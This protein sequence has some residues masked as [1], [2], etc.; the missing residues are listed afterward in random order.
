MGRVEGRRILVTRAEED[1]RS[2]ADRL[3]DWGAHA[4][5]LACLTCRFRDDPR[6]R[7]A[8]RGAL[9]GADWLALTSRRGVDAVA[10]LAPPELLGRRRIA[11]VGETTARRCRERLER[12]DLVAPGGTGRALAETLAGALT[13]DV[14]AGRRPVVAVAAADKAPPELER[15]LDPLGVE[16]RRVAVYETIPAPP[17]EPRIDLAGW[18]I[19]VILLASPSAV[20]GLAAQA[21]FPPS[22][23]LVS[24]GPST[25]EAIRR[26]G[27]PVAGEAKTRDLEGLL[28]AMP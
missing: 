3:R 6:T 4:E 25:S 20:E 24:I 11:S 8:L 16:V 17:R 15:T 1:A 5:V 19:E 14:A 13:A 7:A 18:G 9:D 22:T 21:T 26:A 27:W 23:H 28:E 2:W 12:V 10:A